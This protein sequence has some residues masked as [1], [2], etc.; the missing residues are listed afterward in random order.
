MF[1]KLS[2]EIN[3]YLN[4]T[5][6]EAVADV[7]TPSKLDIR[8]G[9]IV[10]VSKHPEADSLYVEK[11]DLGEEQPRTIVSGLVNYV[12]IEEMQ[13][14][15]VLVL[16]NLKAAKMRGIE[17]QGMVLCASQDEPKAVEPLQPPANAKPG[18]RV[19]VE[20]YQDGEP[21]AVLNPKKKVWEK[22]QVDLKTSS[23]L[24]AQWQ[25]NNLITL[26]DGGL[27]TCKSLKNVPI[28]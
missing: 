7:I 27:I 14:R 23:D 5:E 2:F 15:M 25:G 20:N 10:E 11:I 13:D 3:N 26:S 6:Q 8:I 22:L 19:I 1:Q 9:K 24:I 21:D 16:C 4:F 12:P 17:S 28:K 18:E